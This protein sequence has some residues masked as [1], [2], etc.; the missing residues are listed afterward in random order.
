MDGEKVVPLTVEGNATEKQKQVT[1]NLSEVQNSLTAPENYVFANKWVINDN[2]TPC[3]A[4]NNTMTVKFADKNN[5]QVYDAVS[6]NVDGKKDVDIESNAINLYSCWNPTNGFDFRI[7]N[8][9]GDASLSVKADNNHT[10]YTYRDPLILTRCRKQIR[11][12]FR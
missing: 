6:V 3:D 12:N 10:T 5:N 1:Y 4:T 8:G 9:I 7:T 11:W 2:K